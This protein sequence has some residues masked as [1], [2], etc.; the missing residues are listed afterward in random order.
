MD[1]G[2]CYQFVKMVYSMSFTSLYVSNPVR[3]LSRR[4]AALPTG[5]CSLGPGVLRSSDISRRGG[6]RARGT[7]QL[8]EPHWLVGGSALA[9]LS[10]TLTKPRCVGVGLRNA[11][12]Q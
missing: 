4:E 2:H 1:E 10:R 8:L 12:Y 9:Q 6:G 3:E 5:G 11:R 7:R